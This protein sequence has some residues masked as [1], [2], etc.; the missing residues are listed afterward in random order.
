MQIVA[1]GYGWRPETGNFANH[2][3]IL[4]SHRDSSLTE[5]AYYVDV[6][7]CEAE[8]GGVQEVYVFQ[9]FTGG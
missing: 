2:S 8:E 5:M 1:Q 6:A 4:W 7:I 3:R 9:D